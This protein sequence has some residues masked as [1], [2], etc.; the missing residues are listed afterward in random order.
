MVQW[1]DRPISP[2]KAWQRIG[3]FSVPFMADL[4]SSNEKAK[5]EGITPPGKLSVSWLSK[6]TRNK[7][8]QAPHRMQGFCLDMGFHLMRG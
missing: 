4:V 5:W 8:Q 7:V 3:R 6:D 2:I 1:T